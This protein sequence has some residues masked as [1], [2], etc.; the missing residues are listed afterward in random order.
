MN[1]DELE[2]RGIIAF[3]VLERL[4]RVLELVRD[5][6]T[7]E[8]LYARL[9]GAYSPEYVVRFKFSDGS[10]AMSNG[11]P[12]MLARGMAFSESS[13]RGTVVFENDMSTVGQAEFSWSSTSGW[14]FWSATFDQ[15]PQWERQ[16]EAVE[17]LTKATERLGN[18]LDFALAPPMFTPSSAPSPSKAILA[19]PVFD[20]T[21][22]DEE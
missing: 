22:K 13:V 18:S 6:W 9:L 14:K 19:L 3:L 17:R 16:E 20:I 12:A 1:W 21:N 11:P 5:Q 7:F 10:A 8:A 4:D 15:R 2:G